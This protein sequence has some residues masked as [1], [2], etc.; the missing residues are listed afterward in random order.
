[1]KKIFILC[2]L[3]LIG[4]APSDGPYE[5]TF[6]FDDRYLERGTYKDGKKDG[7]YTTIFIKEGTIKE[8]GTYKDGEYDGLYKEYSVSKKSGGLAEEGN[9]K[10]GLQIGTWKYYTGGKLS[11]TINYNEDGNKDGVE[12]A[13][14]RDQNGNYLRDKIEKQT[15]KN[16]VKEGPP[17]YSAYKKKSTTRSSSSGSQKGV[18]DLRKGEITFRIVVRE[19]RSV[20]GEL[21]YSGFSSVYGVEGNVSGIIKNNTL[22]ED[23]AFKMGTIDRNGKWIKYDGHTISKR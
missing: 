13:Y 17:V 14:L 16:G 12:T 2:S 15:W 9:Y 23:G 3:I 22:Y 18:Y 8:E 19:D 20:P 10:A 11:R 1:M 4:C 7:P 21:F 6:S 5:Q